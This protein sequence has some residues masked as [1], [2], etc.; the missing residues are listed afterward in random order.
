M[1]KVVTDGLK[2]KILGK[3]R[4]KQPRLLPSLEKE[5]KLRPGQLKMVLRELQME[6]LVVVEKYSGEEKAW[7][8]EGYRVDYLGRDPTQKRVLKKKKE[9]VKGREPESEESYMYMY[10]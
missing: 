9:K 1:R 6:G 5:L 7:L 4:E 2:K 8:S 10:V 3:L